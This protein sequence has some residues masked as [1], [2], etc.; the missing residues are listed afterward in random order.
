MITPIKAKSKTTP[1][2]KTN[3]AGVDISNSYFFCCFRERLTIITPIKAKSKS[4]PT[5][6]ISPI[7]AAD[8][9]LA[10]LKVTC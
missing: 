2:Y 5:V 8:M 4:A 7:A 3:A 6:M 1:K 9:I 10:P